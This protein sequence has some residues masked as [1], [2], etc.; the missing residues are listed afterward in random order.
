M[1]DEA[2][3]QLMN[4]FYQVLQVQKFS[5]AETLRQAQLS[6]IKQASVSCNAGR[7]FILTGK[8][9]VSADFGF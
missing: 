1:D 4:A 9:F 8:G 7:L 5:K 6:L 2:T 3:Q